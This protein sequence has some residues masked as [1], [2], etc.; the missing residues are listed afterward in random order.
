M[1]DSCASAGL[2]G[3]DIASSSSRAGLC[4]SRPKSKSSSNDNAHADCSRCQLCI[5]AMCHAQGRRGVVP[6]KH[7][8][9][10]LH[11]LRRCYGDGLISADRCLVMSS[12]PEVGND[13]SLPWRLERPMNQRLAERGSEG[14]L[15]KLNV[16]PQLELLGP[17]GNG[18]LSFI[19]YAIPR[20]YRAASLV[21]GQL[22]SHCRVD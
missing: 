14:K 12:H 20:A 6:S 22:V 5:A 10:S 11:S 18:W 3:Q 19:Y 13:I 7:W 4:K 2:L 17:R 15:E 8:K 9:V 16:S 21:V 1:K